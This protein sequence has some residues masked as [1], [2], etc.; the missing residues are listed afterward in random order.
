MTIAERKARE[1]Y[2]RENP[3]RPIRQAKPGP[4][5]CELR[6]SY[7][8]AATDFGLRRFFMHDDGHWYEIERPGRMSGWRFMEYRPTGFSLSPE[9]LRSVIRRAEYGTHEYRG[10]RFYRKPKH[11]KLYWRADD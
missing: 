3:W 9:R 10:G 11:Y 7:F 2:D 8:G 5:I 4:D 6:G 1:A